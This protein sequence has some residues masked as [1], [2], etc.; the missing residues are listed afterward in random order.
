MSLIENSIFCFFFFVYSNK[1]T[2]TSTRNCCTR[3]TRTWFIVNRF[4]DDHKLYVIGAFSYCW[5]D[6]NESC[7]HSCNM[8]KQRREKKCCKIF[9]WTLKISMSHCGN[10]ISNHLKMIYWSFSSYCSHFFSFVLSFFLIQ[11]SVD[12][13]DWV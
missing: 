8:Y 6:W 9:N 2:G 3:K 11:F 13:F 1:N 5:F 10:S 12:W 4:L 7:I